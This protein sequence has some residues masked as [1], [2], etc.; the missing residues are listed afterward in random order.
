MRLHVL[1]W[2]RKFEKHEEKCS[3][4]QHK[5]QVKVNEMQRAMQKRFGVLLFNRYLSN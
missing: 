5:K 2:L 1:L 3:G 4:Q